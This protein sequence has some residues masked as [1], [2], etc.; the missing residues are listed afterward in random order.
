MSNQTFWVLKSAN[1]EVAILTSRWMGEHA[2]ADMVYAYRECKDRDFC[3]QSDVML[4]EMGN[5]LLEN[6]GSGLG[7]G[8]ED[9]PSVHADF[10]LGTIKLVEDGVVL[11]Q[12][13]L[14]Y[15]MENKAVAEA[16][17]AKY[18]PKD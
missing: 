15:V 2:L 3:D 18:I 12:G 10:A 1:Y 14:K 7:P 11:F 16:L 9:K 8:N 17:I 6:G 4:V 13:D 5:W